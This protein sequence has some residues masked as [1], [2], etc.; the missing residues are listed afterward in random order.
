MKLGPVKRQN[1]DPCVYWDGKQFLHGFLFIWATGRYPVSA[2]KVVLCCFAF[3]S[4]ARIHG[5]GLSM[6]ENC[7]FGP[8]LRKH[9][10]KKKGKTILMVSVRMHKISKRQVRCALG[11]I[12]HKGMQDMAP[13][14]WLKDHCMDRP[15]ST[16]SGRFW[17]PFQ[18]DN[19]ADWTQWVKEFWWYD[20]YMSAFVV[21]C[22][23]CFL[24]R[25]WRCIEWYVSP[26][27]RS[28]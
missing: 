13:H 4:L 11:N 6:K 21:F 17:H 9:T 10:A 15:S 3:S 19:S 20:W 7:P 2:S 26:D 18:N 12:W 27:S 5:N 23:I 14:G 25:F 22:F 28:L 8:C 24:K 1:A 16:A